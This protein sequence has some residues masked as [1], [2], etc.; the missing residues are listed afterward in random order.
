[1]KL[2]VVYDNEAKEGLQEGWGFSCFI[3][4][5]EKNILFDTG[6]D[7]H[8]LLANMSRLSISPMNI[9]TLVLSHQHWDHIGGLPTILDVKPDMEIYVPAS[10]SP[11]LR[12]DVSSRCQV[13]HE[14]KDAEDICKNVYTTGELGTDIREQ[15]LVIDSGKGFFVVTGCTHPGLKTVLDSAS[16]FGEVTGIIG[17]LHNSHEYDLLGGMQLIG[18]GHCTTHKDKIREKYPDFFEDIFAGYI[19]KF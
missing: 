12:R 18:A 4:T 9:D 15:S 16:V 6:W 11:H 10:F 8:L 17:G 5:P 19:R 13:L 1:M 2:T 7:G 3:E 14:I